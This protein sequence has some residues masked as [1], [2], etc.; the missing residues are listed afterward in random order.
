MVPH[1]WKA[2]GSTTGALV[3]NRGGYVMSIFRKD[4]VFNSL[5]VCKA[6]DGFMGFKAALV[7]DPL[8]RALASFHEVMIRGHT[9][10][11]TS[12]KKEMNQSY[13]TALFEH[14]L[15]ESHDP[16]FWPQA[17]YL[18]DPV[19]AKHTLDYIGRSENADRELQFIFGIPGLKVKYKSGPGFEK[20]P[21][22]MKET[23]RDLFRINI[24]SLPSRTVEKVCQKYLVDYCCFGLEFPEACRHLSCQGSF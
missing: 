17:Q 10:K 19:G 3:A 5:D 16:H 12:S 9:R 14:T 1:I 21:D 13:L 24:P 20:L 18:V 7:R 15:N 6:F 8:T 23:R 22:W 4:S 2:A 11:K